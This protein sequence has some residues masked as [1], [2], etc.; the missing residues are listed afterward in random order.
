M[1]YENSSDD[2][3]SALDTYDNGNMTSVKSPMSKKKKILIVSLIAVIIA[4]I[5]II[6][7]VVVSNNSKNKPL[8]ED[9][10]ETID[11]NTSPIPNPTPTS[12]ST[13]ET[14]VTT[15]PA[16]S[17]SVKP[18]P[19]DINVEIKY[20]TF[21][22]NSG[23]GE[24]TKLAV[25]KGQ[26]VSLESI[27]A[28]MRSGYRLHGWCK[29]TDCQNSRVAF[30]YTFEDEIT[31]YAEWIAEPQTVEVSFF[32]RGGTGS[33]GKHEY[34]AEKE[35]ESIPNSFR[36]S[37]YNFAGWCRD[38]NCN[39]EAVFPTKFYINTELYAKWE[40]MPS[41][42]GYISFSSN[43]GSGQTPPLACSKQLMVQEMTN[44]FIPP[45]SDSYFDG[46]S[47]VDE[48]AS[49]NLNLLSTNKVVFPFKFEKNVTFSAIWKKYDTRSVKLHYNNQNMKD[50]TFSFRK[51]NE[52]Q[53]LGYPEIDN[54][55][56]A[57][58]FSDSTFTPESQIAFP[59][60]IDKDMDLYAKWVE[61]S[62]DGAIDFNSNGAYGKMI[63]QSCHFGAV[64][65][66]IT[67]E[68]NNPGYDFMGWFLNSNCTENTKVQFP[69]V[70]KESMTLYASWKLN[71]PE[72]HC[73]LIYN[74]NGGP[75]SID[76][77]LFPR[78]SSESTVLERPP[79]LKRKDGYV[80]YAWVVELNNPYT[81]FYSYTQTFTFDDYKI[82]EN[83]TVTVY[84][85][86]TKDYYTVSFDL[87]GGEGDVHP[88]YV[89][90]QHAKA[91]Y[92]TIPYFTITKEDNIFE[93]WKT[94]LASFEVIR[95]YS[96][97]S[98]GQ[99]TKDITLYASYI[100]DVDH[101]G[102][103]YLK[104]AGQ[105]LWMKGMNPITPDRWLQRP[106]YTL[107]GIPW[108]S[109]VD[110][111]WDA[112]KLIPYVGGGID[113][114]MCWA[115]AASNALHWFAD[116]NKDYIDKYFKL[117]PNKT[118]PDTHFGGVKDS[119]IFQE[120]RQKWPNRGNYPN[121][122]Y[123]WWIRG[124]DIIEGGGYFKDV[125]EG[126]TLVTSTGNVKMRRKLFNQ[127]ITSA[128]EGNKH[129]SWNIDMGDPHALT[130]YGAYYDSDG[131]IRTVYYVDS[132]TVNA[133]TVTGEI[134]SIEKM[135]IVYFDDDVE[136][137][138]NDPESLNNVDPIAYYKSLAPG[139]ADYILELYAYD[140]GTKYW[141]QYFEEHPVN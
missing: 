69:F 103:N 12:S 37:G 67:P 104:Y 75:G 134:V 74:M 52:V 50:E 21:D 18:N 80:F 16:E 71:V 49:S 100:P 72:N 130:L 41:I 140:T 48:S 79:I 32:P 70:F 126:A 94:D 56:F 30:P 87:Q 135:D 119:G 8:N 121:R 51:G 93:A 45:T 124:V 25:G 4:I 7:A 15:P 81:T 39:V 33:M 73:L 36:R 42:D 133:Q 35:I 90:K 116:R 88:F 123:M 5:V 58:W 54:Y 82:K 122:A 120:F 108:R 106:Y 98:P 68:F 43:S 3:L 102:G 19:P 46:Y 40:Q 61:Y 64:I 57:G 13:Q 6:V 28:F 92:I 2:N 44:N 20:L 91:N 65:N 117:H 29:T 112:K 66:S 26:L 31:L 85:M 59:F 118:R 114:N 138:V 128:L 136:Q 1:P 76:S 60:N 129:L 132:N 139:Y 83:G 113:E 84:A 34:I 55:K 96:F 24:S 131:W 105:T 107:P 38:P 63:S 89:D 10:L 78:G 9:Q 127:F 99:I 11:N 115:G 141:E 110:N 109:G 62:I 23:N 137:P 14:L 101:S 111:W 22:H 86:W 97:L 47:I 95:P 77:A 17:T 27:P 53:S 125:F